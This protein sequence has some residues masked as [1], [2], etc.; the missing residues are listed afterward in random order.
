MAITKV[1]TDVIT[2][3]AVTAP[4]LAADSVITAKIADN[5]VTAAK[6]AAGA[7]TDQVAGI[8]SAADATAITIDSSENVGIGATSP[9]D[10]YAGADN[11]VIKQASGEGG[12]TVVTADST[13]GYLLFAD[14]TSGN[15]AYRGQVAYSHSSDVLNLVSSGTMVFKTDTGRTEKMRIDSS[16]NVGIGDINP[17]AKLDVNSGTTNTMAHFH[18][19]DDNGFIELKDDDTTGYIGVQNDYVY[20]GGA[21]STSTQNLVINDGTGNVGIG[22]TSPEGVLHVHGGDSGSSYTADGADKLIIEHSDSVAIDLRTPASNQ[23]LIMFSDG[24]R[25]QGL[26]GYNHSNDSLRFSNS[27][28]QTRMT[29]DNS[30]NVGI[31]TTS[32]GAK[33]TVSNDTSSTT[34]HFQ[35]T[36]N[37]TTFEHLTLKSTVDNN[38]SRVNQFFET[39]QGK[40]AK[41]EGRQIAGGSNAYGELN[42]FT[43]DNGTL[44]EKLAIKYDGSLFLKGGITGGVQ[45]IFFN[46]GGITI[47]YQ[48]SYTLSGILNTGAL[49]AIGQT[50]SQQGVTYD[51]CLIFA[52]TGTAATEIANPSGRFAI[53]SSSTSNKTNIYVSGN[54]VVIMNEVGTNQPY[55]IAVFRFQGT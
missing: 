45:E 44:A 42:F 17:S 13:T 52:E 20:I 24:T 2:D 6:I 40:I 48:S 11:L 53:N 32:P 35:G 37:S 8:S 43:S 47:N 4:K 46:N 14:G 1:T 23:A 28:N 30:G 41:I 3:L 55:S 38:T 49:I 26:I 16:G 7:L 21:A 19:T 10:Y 25:S 12:I 36:T 33:L 54:S 27:G 22:T 5:A 31:G 15:A 34:A 18:S 50:R 29:I 51:H 39:G 9:T